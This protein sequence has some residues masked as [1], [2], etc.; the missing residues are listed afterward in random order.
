MKIKIRKTKDK[1]VV[2]EENEEKME[3]FK[4]F[5]VTGMDGKELARYGSKS[6]ADKWLCI[7][8]ADLEPHGVYPVGIVEEE[9][10]FAVYLVVRYELD[11]Y[12]NEL[13]YHTY[14]VCG[15]RSQAAAEK[16]RKE[17]FDPDT[18]KLFYRIEKIMLKD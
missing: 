10:G 4:Q 9:E 18:H 17:K 6:G 8:E 14:V 2:S 13:D 7:L 1:S 12:H 5:I 15:F 16:F 11:T 3:K